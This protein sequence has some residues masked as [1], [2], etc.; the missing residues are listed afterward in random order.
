[1]GSKPGSYLSSCDNFPRWPV[2][3]KLKETLSACVLPQAA[4]TIDTFGLGE[5]N[6]TICSF[7]LSYSFSPEPT[8][9]QPCNPSS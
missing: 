8:S 5:N 2:T 9:F 1:M 7:R 4:D 3:C 6:V